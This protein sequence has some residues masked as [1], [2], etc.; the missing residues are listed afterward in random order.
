[1]GSSSSSSGKYGE[2]IRNASDPE[3]S[4]VAVVCQSLLV[5]TMASR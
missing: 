3:R 2:S 4:A 1:M 5:T